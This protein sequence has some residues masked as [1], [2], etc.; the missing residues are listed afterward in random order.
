[1]A[2]ANVALTN[3]F[4]EW[5]TITNQ[6]AYQ[7]NIFEGN[8]PDLYLRSNS[9]NVNVASAFAKANNVA[10]GANGYTD[11][12]SVSTGAGANAYAN[13]VWSRTNTRTDVAGSQANT[14]ATIASQSSNLF[15]QVTLAGANAAIGAG[16]NARAA[17]L[18]TDSTQISNSFASATIT[19]A[20]T[21]VGAGANAFASATVAGANNYLLATIAGANTAVGA[22]ANARSLINS[23]ATIAGTLTSTGSFVAGTFDG[24]DDSAAAPAFRFV[25][26]QNMGMYRV[27]TNN[28]AFSTASTQRMLISHT[29]RITGAGTSGSSGFNG[30][31]DR[32]VSG[33]NPSGG[34]DGDIWY[35]V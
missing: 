25:N 24:R 30:T 3:T 21:A 14:F 33:S 4:D 17:V 13:L 35:K 31:G 20:N 11:T 16:A 5:R 15:F 9:I 26:A 22:G 10:L 7:N 34:Q 32:Y 8:V 29:G 12:I 23:T 18:A 6:L 19:G 27:S 28:L 2:I 1:M